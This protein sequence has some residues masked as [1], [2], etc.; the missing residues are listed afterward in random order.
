MSRFPRHAKPTPPPT[1]RALRHVARATIRHRK[2]IVVVT[3]LFVVVAGLLGGNVTSK[4]SRGGFDVSSEQSVHAASVLASEFHNGS[5]NIL[6]LVHATSG[7][8]DS[9]VG[10]R[11]PAPP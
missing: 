11:P 4:L 8:V 5:D 2:A 7:T 1:E 10:G 6:I 9:A 3:G